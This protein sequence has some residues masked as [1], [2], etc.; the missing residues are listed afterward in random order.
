MD[1]N[2][3]LD[4]LCLQYFQDKAYVADGIFMVLPW[5]LGKTF[6]RKCCLY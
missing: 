1:I 5:R 6:I 2:A 3:K 4:K